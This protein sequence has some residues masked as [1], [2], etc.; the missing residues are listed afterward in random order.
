[1]SGRL[2]V[3]ITERKLHLGSLRQVRQ[4]MTSRYLHTVCDEARCPNRS[5]CFLRG[6]ATFL[7]MGDVCTRSCRYCSIAH[8]R[9]RP[10]D[11]QEPFRLVNAVKA[12]GLRHVVVT[13]VDRDDLADG[14]ASHFARVVEALKRL[15]PK[16]TVEV[17][18]P[19]FRGSM[20]AVDT[21]ILAGP[22]VFNHNVETVPRLYPQVRRQ[23]RYTWALEVLRR[24][25]QQAPEIVRKSG[26]M[27]GL[28]ETRAEVEAVLEDLLD[29]GCQVVTIGQYLQPTARQVP[30]ARYWH[31]EEFHQLAE[32]GR[33]LGLKVI[34]GP[35][36]R[37]SYHAEEAFLNLTKN[38]F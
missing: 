24:V 27:V 17:L 15:E 35:F 31:P 7:I 21:V 29:V 14:G 18:T 37:S 11:P 28:G 38:T 23:G 32:F 30:V 13:S 5:E 2:P 9:P 16:V 12:L 3:W 33:G 1:M 36:I 10:L 8:G 34:A 6:T 19:D 4:V 25:S 26:L 20:A 22:H